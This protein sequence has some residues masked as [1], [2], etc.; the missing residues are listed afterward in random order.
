[1]A[2]GTEVQRRVELRMRRARLLTRDDAPQVWA[3]IDESVLLR[4]LGSAEVM[5]EQL[6][7]LVRAAAWPNVTL[8]IVPLDVTNASAPA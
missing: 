8:Q 4:V 2:S 1:S 3:I 7:H 6:E 5:R